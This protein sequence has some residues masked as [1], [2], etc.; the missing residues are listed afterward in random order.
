MPINQLHTKATRLVQIESLKCQKPQAAQERYSPSETLTQR[1]RGSESN[2][3]PPFCSLTCASN[4]AH[5]RRLHSPRRPLRPFRPTLA[6]VTTTVSSPS[7]QIICSPH[8][9]IVSN[10][11]SDSLCRRNGAQAHLGLPGEP[12]FTV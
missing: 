3:I 2:L 5:G 4:G 9:P 6:P 8:F 1:A 10:L 11:L 7:Y 12:L